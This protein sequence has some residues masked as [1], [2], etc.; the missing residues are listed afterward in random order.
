[1]PRI[2]WLS[3]QIQRLTKSTSQ[4]CWNNA[5]K[6]ENDIQS[7]C[8]NSISKARDC[9]H[10]KELPNSASWNP[11]HFVSLIPDN[12]DSKIWFKKRGRRQRRQNCWGQ[13]TE[14]KSEQRLSPAGTQRKLF[15]TMTKK[16]K[17]KTQRKSENKRRNRNVDPAL[18]INKRRQHLVTQHYL[19]I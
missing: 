18:L 11:N 14:S 16:I 12:N 1:M 10:W 5:S 7:K 9:I 13:W 17:S 2:C 4:L 19:N 3:Q 15:L 6:N 8:S